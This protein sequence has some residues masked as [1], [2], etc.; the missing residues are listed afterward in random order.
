MSRILLRRLSALSA[1]VTTPA[2]ARITQTNLG[3]T[4]EFSQWHIKRYV[5]SIATNDNGDFEQEWLPVHTD[6]SLISIVAS[7]EGDP[8]HRLKA[9]NQATSFALNLLRHRRQSAALHGNHQLQQQTASI[10]DEA[11]A[12]N[13]H[14]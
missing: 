4:D 8:S 12:D 7:G 3:Q 1:T 6:P 11:T 9:A 13:D 14:L 5:C 10:G 2:C